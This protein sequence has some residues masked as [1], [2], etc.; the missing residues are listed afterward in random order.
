[1]K[2][3]QER[4]VG[5]LALAALVVAVLLASNQ[6]ASANAAPGGITNNC[7]PDFK[8]HLPPGHRDRCTCDGNCLDNNV[9]PPLSYSCTPKVEKRQVNG[10]E[11]EV[12]SC[13]C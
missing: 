6:L 1:M 12:C 4:L 10:E 13:Y 2:A 7:K 11:V 3:L 8:K 5:A 9:N